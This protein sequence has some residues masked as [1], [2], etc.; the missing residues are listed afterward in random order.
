MVDCT[1]DEKRQKEILSKS[2]LQ[3]SR[4]ETFLIMIYF[5]FD[6]YIVHEHSVSI[7]F[8]SHCRFVI[9]PRGFTLKRQ[10]MRKFV[11]LS[12]F[13]QECWKNLWMCGTHT[14]FTYVN[15]LHFPLILYPTHFNW[16]AQYHKLSHSSG[17]SSVFPLTT[18]T[19]G[20][21]VNSQ[22]ATICPKW[23]QEFQQNTCQH[24]HMVETY[25][26]LEA[27]NHQTKVDDCST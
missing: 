9:R 19:L 25:F 27:K 24:I 14:C 11:I 15:C 3:T 8:C 16:Y 22:Y 4:L 12:L 7:S 10:F 1:H 13:V 6:Q 18:A 23:S 26:L 21:V 5:Y 20:T 2:C 17:A